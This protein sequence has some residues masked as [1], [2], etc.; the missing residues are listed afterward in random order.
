M[1]HK[2]GHPFLDLD[3]VSGFLRPK[4]VSGLLFMNRT[5]EHPF[6]DLDFGCGF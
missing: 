4:F 5:V 2:V 3:V 1:N 6:L